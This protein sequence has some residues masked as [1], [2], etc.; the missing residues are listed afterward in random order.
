MNANEEERLEERRIKKCEG[1][2]LDNPT[3]ELLVHQDDGD[4]DGSLG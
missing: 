2:R 3:L 4:G 1:L